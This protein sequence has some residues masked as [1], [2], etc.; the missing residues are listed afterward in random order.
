MKYR[1]AVF[2]MDGTILNTL[3]DLTDSLNWALREAGHRG[4]FAADQVR[5]FYGSA[6][7]TAISR[8]LSVENGAPMEGI[9]NI[10]ESVNPSVYGVDPEEVRRIHAL[11]APHYASHCQIKP[12]PYDGIPEL[13][14]KLRDAGVKT[15][16]VSNKS[17]EAVHTL[18]KDLFNGLFDA[19]AGEQPGIR[20]KPAPDMTL[21][22]LRKMGIPAESAVYI[23]DTEIDLQTAKNSG[24]ECIAVTWGFRS[25]D[26]L[27][28]R[29]ASVICHTAGEVYREITGTEQ[30]SHP[31]L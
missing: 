26:V 10:G 16:V 6:I 27:K 1:A 30:G 12:R 3:E 22:A 19:A 29:G 17:D 20:R 11:Y 31:P 8:A 13:I 25:E 7:Q 14:R 24:M 28:S 23:G 5:H 18:V 4:N 2:D 9:E 21:F 15:A